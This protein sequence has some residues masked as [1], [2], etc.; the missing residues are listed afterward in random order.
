MMCGKSK[1]EVA[2]IG[3]NLAESQRCLPGCIA[4]FK[5]KLNNI[6]NK[7]GCIVLNTVVIYVNQ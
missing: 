4:Q 5:L 7:K 6:F 3:K 2:A 1:N